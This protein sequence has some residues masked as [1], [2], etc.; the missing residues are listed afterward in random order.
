MCLSLQPWQLHCLSNP[1]ATNAANA[2][3]CLSCSCTCCHRVDPTNRATRLSTSASP[4][5]LVSCRSMLDWRMDG[6]CCFL[7]LDFPLIDVN[8]GTCAHRHRQQWSLKVTV[9][10]ASN[11][12]RDRSCLDYVIGGC[13]HVHCF[14]SDE[15]KRR[16]RNRC[17]QRRGFGS[18]RSGSRRC[19]S[20]RAS[21]VDR[22]LTQQTMGSHRQLLQFVR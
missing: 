10:G 21:I 1:P 8:A 7:D 22:W 9:A 20:P 11:V 3:G 5:D 14:K 6:N 12:H 4:M 13:F 17:H 19:A 18:W 16:G 15:W 2:A